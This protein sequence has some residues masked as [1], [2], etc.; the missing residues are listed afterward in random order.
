MY[1]PRET[2]H[3]DRKF[4]VF[5][6]EGPDE[7]LFDKDPAPPPPEIQNSTNPPSAPGDPIEAGIFN[8]SNQTEY[9]ILF[10]NRGLKVYDDME[11]APENVPLVY[12]TA[13]DTLFE[14]QT[15][16]WDGIDRRAVVA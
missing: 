4:V 11:P 5:R 9:I 2:F 6:E 13:T 12:T 3:C 7:G 16:G 14:I 15:W 1:V 8:A 10:R